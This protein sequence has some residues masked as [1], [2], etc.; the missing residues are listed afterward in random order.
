MTGYQAYSLLHVAG[1]MLWA[2]AGLAMTLLTVR[3]FGLSFLSG[4]AFCGPE[5]PRLA[6]LAGA[7]LGVVLVRLAT[8]RVQ[9]AA[10]A[11]GVP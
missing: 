8:S 2:G 6:K 3:R 11:T 9:A 5:W 4:A 7:I 1:A 10:P